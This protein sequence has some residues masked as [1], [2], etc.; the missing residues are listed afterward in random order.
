MIRDDRYIGSQGRRLHDPAL[1]TNYKEFVMKQNIT[2]R[3]ALSTLTIALSL[4]LPA[5][6]AQPAKPSGSMACVWGDA[7]FED[8]CANSSRE[9]SAKAAELARLAKAKKASATVISSYQGTLYR[10]GGHFG[11]EDSDHTLESTG[12]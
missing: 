6:A 12:N 10:N 11:N 5:S 4:A 8:G 7:T 3:K 2:A 9:T 1:H